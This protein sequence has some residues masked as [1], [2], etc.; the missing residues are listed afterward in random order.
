MTGLLPQYDMTRFRW[1]NTLLLLKPV[2]LSKDINSRVLEKS[3]KLSTLI[4]HYLSHLNHSQSHSAFFDV[5]ALHLL[6]MQHFGD[7]ETV[8]ITLFSKDKVR[9]FILVYFSFLFSLVWF[10]WFDLVCLVCFVFLVVFC[11][12]FLFLF[13][14]FC[15]CFLFFIFI[16]C[17]CFCFLLFCF[18]VFCFCFLFFIFCF[19]FCFLFFYLFIFYFI[20]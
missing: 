6:V 10:V 4:I 15:F 19:V 2:V 8:K 5:Y 12:L 13:F 18:F 9:Y 20:R 16:F 1:V 17:F 14:V 7:W 11:F 3:S